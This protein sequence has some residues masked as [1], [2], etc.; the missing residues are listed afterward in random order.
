MKKTDA[1]LMLEDILLIQSYSY[2]EFKMQ[3][4]IINWL[5]SHKI[6][7]TTDYD[8]NILVTKGKLKSGEYYPCVTSHMD[9]V[10]NIVDNYE[11][12]RKKDKKTKHNIY[13]SPTGVGGDDKCGIY[14]C[15]RMLL[16]FPKIKACFFTCEESG[17]DGSRHVDL[18]FFD[19][20]GYLIGIDRQGISDY[21]NRHCGSETTSDKWEHKIE[22]V[23]KKH[24]RKPVNGGVTDALVIFERSVGITCINM[25]CAYY[26]PHTVNEYIDFEE[27][28]M[29][30]KFIV[31]LIKKAGYNKY[32]KKYE[33]A[34][35]YTSRTPNYD[36]FYDKYPRYSP[37]K[38][39]PVKR[40]FKVGE[41]YYDVDDELID[42]IIQNTN[43]DVRLKF[44]TG[45]ELVAEI[46]WLEYY[47]PDEILYIEIMAQSFEVEGDVI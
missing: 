17:Q 45:G 26:R 18:S 40:A 8:G 32:E 1:M 21:V 10:H 29:T 27:L 13:N 12:F 6:S 46:E 44:V 31:D 3:S 4:F 9:T 22:S 43:R 25:S 42:D 41:R 38:H 14:C 5:N 28:E 24:K 11:V 19:N 37:P 39:Q 35:R 7:F 16:Y 34:Y 2:R 30:R 15:L 33:S 20:V 47:N 36:G 23:L